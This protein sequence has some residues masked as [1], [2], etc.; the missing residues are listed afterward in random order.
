MNWAF[1]AGSI[2]R[3]NGAVGAPCLSRRT[4]LMTAFAFCLCV[5]AFPLIAT[6]SEQAAVKVVSQM[7]QDIGDLYRSATSEDQ[8]ADG[9]EEVFSNYSDMAVISRSVIGPPWRQISERQRAEFIRVFKRYLSEKYARH[10]PEALKGQYS[11]SRVLELKKGLHSVESSV[12]IDGSVPYRLRWHV[13]RNGGRS[14]IINMLTDEF[15]LRGLERT[16]IR[17]LLKQRKG[18][19]DRLIAYLPT[20]YK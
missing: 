14:L 17:S 7:M 19:M 11:I 4:A 13:L 10:F 16:V 2:R 8:I 5:M 18:Q 15:D 9:L 12:S 3:S 20:R 1:A 6:A